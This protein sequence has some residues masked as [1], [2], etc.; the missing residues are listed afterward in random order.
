LLLFQ[1]ATAR[2][3][4][5]FLRKGIDMLWS[6]F[7]VGNFITVFPTLNQS[8][9]SINENGHR[10]VEMNSYDI[11]SCFPHEANHCGDQLQAVLMDKCYMANVGD[12]LQTVQPFTN[13]IPNNF[14]GC[15]MS[16]K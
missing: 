11:F 15:S 16:R 2:K 10:L 13:K 12:R 14:A 8:Q 3:I 5:D 7:K 9:Y 6:R 1:L 4:T